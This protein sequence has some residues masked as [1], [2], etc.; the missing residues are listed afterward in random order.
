MT[1]RLL[2]QH[3]DLAGLYVAGGGIT[4][5]LAALRGSGRAG[6]PV[7]VGYELM[8]VTRT[9]LLDGTMQL[10]IAHPLARLADEAI[11]GM[12]RAVAAGDGG[13]S[14][15]SVIPFEIFVRENI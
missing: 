12:A 11:A 4:G 2:Y 13:G 9:A 8:D 7:V 3:P 14:H 15:G 1:E 5:A 6:A 10:V